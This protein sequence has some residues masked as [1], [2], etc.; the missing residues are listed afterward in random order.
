MNTLSTA[1]HFYTMNFFVNLHQI[2]T[3]NVFDKITETMS[4]RIG[5]VILT[6]FDKKERRDSF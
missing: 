1:I 4:K 6:P 3:N 2:T 5:L